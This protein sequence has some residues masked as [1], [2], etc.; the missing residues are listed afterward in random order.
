L[1]KKVHIS[2]LI[3]VHCSGFFIQKSRLIN[4]FNQKHEIK[5]LHIRINLSY[6]VTHPIEVAIAGIMLPAVLITVFAISPPVAP[7]EAFPL[8]LFPLEL[9]PFEEKK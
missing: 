5:A 4:Q 6:K 1:E 2:R 8:E 9:F 7:F 3:S